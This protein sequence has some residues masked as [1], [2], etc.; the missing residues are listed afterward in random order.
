MYFALSEEKLLGLADEA[1][2]AGIEL[3]VMDDG[4]FRGRNSDTTSLGDW[5]EDKEKFPNGIQDLAKK[6]REKGLEF[7]IWFETGNDFL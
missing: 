7:G 6:V 2:K 3:L 4:W 5:V 1:V